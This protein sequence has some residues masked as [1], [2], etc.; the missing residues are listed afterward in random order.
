MKLHVKIH[1]TL[2][3]RVDLLEIEKIAKKVWRTE[4]PVD[5]H[6]EIILVDDKYIKNLNKKYFK[7]NSTTDVIAFPLSEEHEKS[8]EGEI[9]VSLDTIREQAKRY[10]VSLKEELHRMVIHGILHFLG[11]DDKTARDKQTMTNLENHFLAK[12]SCGY[13][14]L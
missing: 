6:I 7:K 12:Y 5:G 13:E 11:Y 1:N 2:S 10:N 9:Y 4:S 8:F 14:L 3:T